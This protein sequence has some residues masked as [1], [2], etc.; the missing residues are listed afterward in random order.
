MS[1][2]E[3]ATLSATWPFSMV[4][5]SYTEIAYHLFVLCSPLK[6]HSLHGAVH[7]FTSHT[8]SYKLVHMYADVWVIRAGLFSAKDLI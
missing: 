4:L 6:I 1:A 3:A 7:A 2:P 8:P 5:T